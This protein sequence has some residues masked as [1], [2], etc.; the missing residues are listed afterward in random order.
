M[1]S[2]SL[3]FFVCFRPVRMP[4][5]SCPSAPEGALFKCASSGAWEKGDPL[6]CHQTWPEKIP[7]SMI[8][9]AIINGHFR[10]LNWRYLLYKGYIRPM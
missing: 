2:V 4:R 10:N 9:P 3:H 5:P 8:F 1:I 6:P 7:H